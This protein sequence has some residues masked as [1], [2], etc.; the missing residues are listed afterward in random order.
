[1]TY[2]SA[3]ASGQA[4]GP[5][6]LL[7][8]I[9]EGGMGEVWKA[10]D[11]RLE[12]TV[13][14]KL[15]REQF[16][17]R[18]ER[19]A[20]AVAALNHPHICML[21]DVGPNYL[22]MEFV[23][24]R[25]LAGP[26]PAGEA[27]RLAVQ[28]AGALEEAHR[29]G[30]VHRDLKPANILV[31]PSGAKLLDFGLAKRSHATDPEQATV[32]LTQA[33]AILGTVAYMSPEQAQGMPVDARSDIFSFG[34]VIYEMLTGQ[35]A[36]RGATNIEILTSIIHKDPPPLDN[37]PA[38]FERIVSRCLRKA[39]AD[40][41]Q[42]ISDLRQALEQSAA[43]TPAGE[44]A[45]SVAVLPFVNMST[46]P[47]NEYFAD[48]LSE[49]IINALVKVPGLKV[50]ARTSAFSFKGRQVDI[51]HIAD[52]LGVANIVEGSVRRA[53]NRVRITAQ[54]IAASD[55]NHLWSQRYDRDMVDIFAVQDEISRAIVDALKLKLGAATQQAPAARQ[56]EN[57][58]A[59]NLYL[60][61]RFYWNKFTPEGF[62]KA[63]THYEQALAQDPAYAS[64]WAGLAEAYGMLGVMGFERPEVVWPKARQAALQA[65][66]LDEY[67]A[68]AHAVLGG[69]R[70]IY[71]WDYAGAEMEFLKAIEADPSYPIT[72]EW[73][74]FYLLCLGRADEGV[75][76]VRRLREL[77][78]LSGRAIT[79]FGFALYF[80]RRYEDALAQCG[81]SLEILPDHPW[82]HWIMGQTYTH[83]GR[84]EEAIAAL[85]HA[86]ALGASWTRPD[87]AYACAVAGR[88][89]EAEKI[90]EEMAGRAGREYVPAFQ[91]AV[92]YTGL[93]HKDLALDWLEKACHERNVDI[94]F[95]ARTHPHFDSL[96]GLPRYDDLARRLGFPAMSTTHTGG[97][98]HT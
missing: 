15:L 85:E 19:E 97:R 48:G 72:H 98:K 59:Y 6:Q 28:I 16:T 95:A 63:I 73:Y 7:S 91:F 70:W 36:Y 2:V 38:G 41:F 90:L 24:G 74:G 75:A 88:T 52:A 65:V 5:Y 3:G 26:L 18:F 39:P 81:I 61:G 9:G 12:R 33:G 40:R 23:E 25:H 78:P 79:S 58:E 45:Q 87:H 27:L 37:L 55:G 92:V 44:R 86:G 32:S 14:I 11:T 68:A 31:T 35:R 22:V 93:G 47:E 64:A 51:R 20:R 57:I 34:L 94:L 8:L 60:K 80:A 21:Y 1:M 71:D 54:L 29:K 17:D 13:A 50:S 96:R 56:A 42:T 10:R 76:S 84:L 53:G 89:A 67:N 43:K 4:L 83:A 30:F 49:E 77:D 82:T 69:V 66:R 46:D 62:Q